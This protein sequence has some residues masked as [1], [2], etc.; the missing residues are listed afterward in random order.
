M[1]KKQTTS[2]K[3]EESFEILQLKKRI[4]ELEKQLISAL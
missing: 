2:T 3:A 1:A 4:S